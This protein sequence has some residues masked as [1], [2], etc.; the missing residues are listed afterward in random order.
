MINTRIVRL[1]DSD[2]MINIPKQVIEKALGKSNL[3]GVM[4]TF[5]YDSNGSILLKPKSFDSTISDRNA[6]EYL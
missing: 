3:D 1:A 6:Q 2:N 5:W 4:F